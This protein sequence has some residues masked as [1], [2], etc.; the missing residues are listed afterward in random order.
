[1]KALSSARIPLATTPVALLATNTGCT[2]IGMGVGA[3]AGGNVDRY[4]TVT[5]NDPLPPPRSQ[6]RVRVSPG[7][8]E[9][10][11]KGR[12]AGVCDGALIVLNDSGEHAIALEA[13]RDLRVKN[14]TYWRTGL[15]TGAAIG[16]TVDLALLVLL[17]LAE[18]VAKKVTRSN[19]STTNSRRPSSWA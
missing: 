14:G 15:G 2:L 9:E 7:N 19:Q 17:S 8:T 10:R 3:A 12:F 13:V 4:S 6:V 1:M 18:F 11:I 5:P 16:G